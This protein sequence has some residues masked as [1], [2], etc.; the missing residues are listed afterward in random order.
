[1]IDVRWAWIVL[2][3]VEAD[4]EVAEA[5]WSHVTR[6]VGTRRSGS[7]GE[8]AALQ[9]EQ[10]DAWVLLQ[11][12][13]EPSGHGAHLDLVVAGPLADAA[14]DAERLGARV[15]SRSDDL[16]VLASPAGAVF[17]LVP[18]SDGDEPGEQVRDGEPDLLDQ[19]CIDVPAGEYAREVDFWEVLTGWPKRP[20]SLPEFVSLTR[21][22]G[23][24][25][26]LLLQRLGEETGTARAHVDF[27]CHDREVS[28]AAHVEAGASVVSEHEFWTVMRDPVGRVYCLTHRQP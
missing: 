9:P 5:F 14:T 20:G 15:L 8:F 1:M 17:C 10:G 4:A 22:D 24:P 19:I 13:R 28:R 7:R 23:I 26:R 21:P 2:D 3:T 27:A 6:A 25:V 11:R 18:V 16:V 12:E